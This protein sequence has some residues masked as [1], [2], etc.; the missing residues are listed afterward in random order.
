MSKEPAGDV[1]KD[2]LFVHILDHKNVTPPK[3]ANDGCVEVAGEGSSKKQSNSI[4]FDEVALAPTFASESA[5]RIRTKP[6]H[7]AEYCGGNC[8]YHRRPKSSNMS[9]S[10]QH[11]QNFVSSSSPR[12][13][14]TNLPVHAVEYERQRRKQESWKSIFCCLKLLVGKSPGRTNNAAGVRR[15]Q[16]NVALLRSTNTDDSFG[17]NF[18]DQPHQNQLPPQ[19]ISSEESGDHID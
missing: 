9:V 10:A 14:S 11:W 2:S 15:R 13:D 5:R 4:N 8:L 7:L 19:P 6:E 18:D 1:R 17:Y 12:F 16:S 3:M